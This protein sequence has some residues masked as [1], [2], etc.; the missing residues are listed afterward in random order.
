VPNV[1][2]WTGREARALRLA[3][4]M[5]VRGFARHL[6]LTP[7]AVSNWERRGPETRLRY[8]TQQILDVDLAHAAPD[9]RERF[10]A[11]VSDS[12]QPSD[13][14]PTGDNHSVAER[15]SSLG[16]HSAERTRALIAATAR[17]Q[18]SSLPYL[19]PVSTS[20]LSDFV[21]SPFR[22][23]VIKGPPGSGKTSLTH[24]FAEQAATSFDFQLH[25][26]DGRI[27][28]EVDV[29]SLILRYASIGPDRDPLLTLEQECARLRR[30]LIVFIDGA[31]ADAYSQRLCR[32]ID[33][34][35]RQ[36]LTGNLRF[37][38]ILR[39]PPDVDFSA[40]PVLAASVMRPVAETGSASLHIRP[41]GLNEAREVWDA[42]RTVDQLPFARLP[43]KVRQLA[44][45]P[46]YM[47]LLKSAGN[48]DWSNESTAYRL[49]DY[50]V[51]SIVGTVD[52]D[53]ESAMRGM[54]ALAESELRHL[55][56]R[57]LL[58]LRT[59]AA[60]DNR[61]E[62]SFSSPLLR[63]VSGSPRSTF[64][65]DVIR[66]YFLATRL[67]QIIEEHGRSTRSVSALNE[68]AVLAGES[69]VGY[70]ALE[71]TVQCLDWI[72]PELLAR[73]SMSPTVAVATTLP[74]LLEL[75]GDEAVFATDEVLRSSASRCLH[76]TGLALAKILLRMPRLPSAL[77][78]YHAQWTVE[79][80]RQFGSD[81]WDSL[82]ENIEYRLSAGQLRSLLETADLGIAA[83]AVFFASH[84]A[85][86]TGN[87]PDLA[88]P[89]KILE[90]HPDWRVRAA[91]AN[92]LR[93][94]PA[95]RPAAD[96]IITLLMRDRDYKVRAAVADAVG[97]LGADEA[98]YRVTLAMDE[99]W[100]VRERL[101]RGLAT[102][103]ATL[104]GELRAILLTDPTWRDC[105]EQVKTSVERLLLTANLQGS[106]G[107]RARDVALFGLLREI[108]TGSLLLPDEVV[109][110]LVSEGH[111]S[112]HW[113]V[114]QELAGL[115]ASG[116]TILDIRQRKEALRR[117]R[118]ARAVQVALD[119]RD[120]DRAIAVAQAAAA[121]GAQFIEV[122]DPL[123]KASGVA[124]IE[125]LKKAVPDVSVVAEMMS[126]DWGRDQVVLAAEAGADIV[127]LIGPASAASVA[128]AVEASGRLGVPLLLDIPHSRLDRGWIQAMERAGVDG[129]AF[130]TNIDLGIAGPHPL[131]QAEVIRTWTR[132]PVAV[133]GGF[134]T[135]D[136]LLHADSTWDIL[137]VGRSVA[138]AVDPTAA[139][140]Q[141]VNHVRTL[142]R[143]RRC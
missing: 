61:I 7:A 120:L 112:R 140:R 137:I 83:D 90:Q 71:F 34:V 43:S 142:R 119:V 33:S 109:A 48:G 106:E 72:A 53:V 42:S 15:S 136:D 27:D 38:L 133:S 60:V 100:H 65:H 62:P 143:G 107:T 22:V 19:P 96:H 8:E 132:L 113:L 25:F 97:R 17:R 111:S 14:V 98:R 122:G 139:A 40:H 68:A 31:T 138:D 20:V 117:L 47:R 29:A 16:Q 93:G 128:A 81:V 76:K 73:L 9:E 85:T 12:E 74:L 91:L 125:H 54:A 35:L 52:R 126:A 21:S 13:D 56:P 28:G 141:L 82:V 44:R 115:A 5:S 64:D 59:P 87:D 101:V 105:P 94:D 89:L 99:N 103:T 18:T 77:G 102:T 11:L 84:A 66:E 50:C 86:F 39:T 124:A 46:L 118:D 135:T 41:W 123:I 24:H 75:A 80:L 110:R 104:D 49:V 134:S 10:E 30:P 55:V 116:P 108:R 63:Q 131:E 88:A 58:P 26:V 121:A 69:A 51:R 32:E 92:G 129:F 1:G 130:T 95:S 79:I 4:R 114:H 2:L 127:L 78:D 36:V 6:G 45:L 67:A 3:K 57:S 70:G 23:Y 37:G